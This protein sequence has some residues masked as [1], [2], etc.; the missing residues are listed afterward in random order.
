MILRSADVRGALRSRQRGVLLNPYRFGSGAATPVFDG[1]TTGLWYASSFSHKMLTAYGGDARTTR[2]SPGG[3]QAVG[4][5]SNAVDLAGEV[6]YVGATPN[7]GYVSQS[8]DHSGNGNH[9]VEATTTR[10]PRTV[11]DGV[12]EAFGYSFEETDERLNSVNTC[13]AGLRAV[14]IHLRANQFSNI[15][16]GVLFEL[17]RVNNDDGFR[18]YW[19]SGATL[20][21]GIFN[22]AASVGV[23][24]TYATNLGVNDSGQAM[25]FVFNMD[26]ATNGDKVK[27]YLNG[28]FLS[29]TSTVVN[30]TITAD[31]ANRN[32]YIGARDDYS[33]PASIRVRHFGI[34]HA[35]SSA[36]DISTIHTRMLAL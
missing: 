13:G 30:T 19:S 36:G 3:S 23:V 11:I 26:E 20:Q 22:S 17:G 18:A 4:F 25:S 7:D 12:S 27:V 31:F 16:G 2:R 10:Q 8:D 34:H 5:S 14:S 29:P 6:A 28:S 15:H 21:V 1:F 33:L 32:Y 35:A 24:Y 9:F